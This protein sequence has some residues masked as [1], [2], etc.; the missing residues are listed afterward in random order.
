VSPKLNTIRNHKKNGNFISKPALKI[1]FLV[2]IQKCGIP[3]IYDK[4]VTKFW[5]EKK[6]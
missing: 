4:K 5:S 3:K 6:L 2:L 1:N